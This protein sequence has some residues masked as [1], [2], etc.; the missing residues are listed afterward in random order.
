V[1]AGMSGVKD[2]N[3]LVFGGG[4]YKEAV[5]AAKADN[6][7]HVGENKT[8]RQITSLIKKDGTGKIGIFKITDTQAVVKTDQGEILIDAT[9][10]N[11]GIYVKN[12]N[13]ET[14]VSIKNKEIGNAYIPEV[15]N[16]S[17]TK[18]LSSNDVLCSGI[19]GTCTTEANAVIWDNMLVTNGRGKNTITVDLGVSFIQ[20]LRYSGDTPRGDT[21]ATVQLVCGSS[22]I[23]SKSFTLNNVSNDSYFASELL[24]QQFTFSHTT[25]D[26]DVYKLMV[27]VKG[28]DHYACLGDFKMQGTI[29]CT[30]DYE[31]IVIPQTIFAPDGV[32]SM[33]NANH[34]FMVQNTESEQK[35]YAKGLGNGANRTPGSGE[36]YVTSSFVDAIYALMVSPKRIAS[37]CD[38]SVAIRCGVS[39]I[40]GF[41]IRTFN[42]VSINCF[43]SRIPGLITTGRP[44]LY[45]ITSTN[46]RK[47]ASF[48][49]SE[50]LS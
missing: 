25:Y 6:D 5:N 39:G 50:I 24:H 29:T 42:T 14:K 13:G 2:D 20:M 8:G 19:P 28:I 46:L 9:D 4:T 40:N 17:F 32:L 18:Y 38:V 49:S 48:I 10:D 45:P 11:G 16:K 37:F 27:Y 35:I 3:I 7:F 47:S 34:Y 43:G 12:L 30:W 31:E 22:I 33:Y 1:T 21:F 44:S 23:A 15:F 41:G 36:L 26:A